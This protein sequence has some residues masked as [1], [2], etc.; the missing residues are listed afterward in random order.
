MEKEV[1]EKKAKAFNAV[2]FLLS[3]WKK[4]G[5]S[6]F[7]KGLKISLIG[8][9]ITFGIYF[10]WY[11]VWKIVFLLKKPVLNSTDIMVITSIAG[12]ITNLFT[13]PIWIV[14]T[15]MCVDKGNKNILQHFRDIIKEGGIS[16]LWNGFLP[17]LILVLNP[18]INFVVYE[19]LRSMLITDAA[20]APSANAVFLISLISKFM[21][22]IT[23][24]PILTIKTKAFTSN[25]SDSMLTIIAEYLKKEGFVALYRGLY[26][27]LFQTLLYNAF[28]MMAFEKIR[29]LVQNFLA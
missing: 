2:Q 3:I 4:E 12:S 10:F 5:I 14:Q 16:A 27:K 18:V 7:Y 11:R 6:A 9:L 28:M 8:A 24:Y 20:K 13:T 26:A 25:K 17:G 29:H 21:A 15:R 19:K 1:K 22:T 23:T